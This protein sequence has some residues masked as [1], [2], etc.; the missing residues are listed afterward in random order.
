MAKSEQHRQKKLAKKRSKE[1]RQKQE[2]ARRN[3]A[4]KSLVGQMQWASQ[5][6]VHQC[7]VSETIFGPQGIGPVF[8]SRKLSDGRIAFMYALIDSKCLGIKDAGG[9][10]CTPGE[11]D[12]IVRGMNGTGQL[13]PHDASFVRKLVEDAI[14]YAESI[15]FSPHADYRRVSALWGDIDSSTCDEEFTFGYEGQPFYVAGPF[16]DESRQRFIY[17]R[18]CQT[19]GE[20]NFHFTMG[21]QVAP[22]EGFDFSILGPN[23]DQDFDDDDDDDYL[24]DDDEALEL[25]DSEWGQDDGVV[26]GKVVEGRVHEGQVVESQANEGQVVDGATSPPIKRLQWKTPSSD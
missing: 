22:P 1:L 9:R 14:D 23:D 21:G 7:Y 24:D 6:P 5:Y 18:L 11:F 16:D 3:Q 8:L 4:M 15:G 25:S 13:I 19:V 10:L 26:E 20:G 12:E 17:R 2:L